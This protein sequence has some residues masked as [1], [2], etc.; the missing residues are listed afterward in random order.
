MEW[1]SVFFSSFFLGK[2]ELEKRLCGACQT[3][4]RDWSGPA[5]K[6]IE[7]IFGKMNTFWM[8]LALFLWFRVDYDGAL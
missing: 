4:R 5:K 6:R 8:D 7:F 3:R 2:N 1:C